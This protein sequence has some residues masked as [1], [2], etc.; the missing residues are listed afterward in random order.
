MKILDDQIARVVAAPAMGSDDFHS[1]NLGGKGLE[2]LIARYLARDARRARTI[3]MDQ[4]QGQVRPANNG[5][6]KS[7]VAVAANSLAQR[8]RRPRLIPSILNGNRIVRFASWR[9]A[10]HAGVDAVAR[11]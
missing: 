11:R 4:L 9:Q 1:W 5:V 8:D 3:A 2:E 6:E 10:G 7:V